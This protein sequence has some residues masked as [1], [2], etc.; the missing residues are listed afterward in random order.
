VLLIAGPILC[1]TTI[2]LLGLAPNSIVLALVL[3]VGG[4]GGAAFHPP[5]A[6]LVHQHSGHQRALRAAL[7]MRRMPMIERLQEQHEESGLRALRPY[8]RP[9]ALL[10]FIVVLR[11]LTAMAVGGFL[12]QST[13]PVN[14]TFGQTIAPIRAAPVASLVVG[15]AWG[16]GGLI[17][18]LVGL[19]ADRIGIERTLMTMS[20]VPLVAAILAWPLPSGPL[21]TARRASSGI[22]TIETTPEDVAD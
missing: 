17:V 21:A 10:Y 2:T 4:L 8:A 16:M 3:V 12:L 13:L 7:R 1:V 5:A 22:S 20:A 9:L 6:A 15:F 11:T 19:T 18:P 14:V